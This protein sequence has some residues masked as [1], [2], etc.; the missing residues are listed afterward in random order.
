MERTLPE[1]RFLTLGRKVVLVWPARGAPGLAEEISCVLALGAKQVR[2][3]QSVGTPGSLLG[4]QK[5][6]AGAGGPNV[7]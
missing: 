7:L 6:G 5:P 1:Y 4:R 3:D 2:F